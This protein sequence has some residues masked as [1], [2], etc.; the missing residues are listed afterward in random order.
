MTVIASAGA[1]GIVRPGTTHEGCGGV[2]EMA[3]QRGCYVGVV[4]TGGRNPVAG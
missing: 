2:A 1:A 3:I 4:F